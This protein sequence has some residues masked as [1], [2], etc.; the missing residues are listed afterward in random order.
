METAFTKDD[1]TGHL[2]V[3]EF[4]KIGD[5]IEPDVKL[6]RK[7]TGLAL[8]QLAKLAGL[9]N[10]KQLHEQGFIVGNP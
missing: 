2:S 3:V 1:L 5:K 4:K 7:A 6:R 10:E 9:L 8:K